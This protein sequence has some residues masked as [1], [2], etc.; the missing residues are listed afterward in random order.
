MA[1][2]AKEM[3]RKRKSCRTYDGEPLK[4][5]DRAA[6][7]KYIENVDNPFGVPVEFRLLDAD[8]YNL[9]SPVIAG[10]DVYMAAKAPKC[11]NFEIGL[12]YSFEKACLYAEHLGLGTVMLA[13][14]LNRRA[15]EKAMEVKDGEVMPVASPV[16]YPAAKRTIRENLMRKGLN[17]DDRRDP[18][19]IFFVDEYGHGLSKDYNGVFA[20]PLEMLRWAPSA[21]NRQPWRVVVSEGKVH[22]YEEQ[23]LKENSLGDVQ[24]MDVGIALCHFGLTMQEDG[25]EGRF[26]FEDPNLRKPE[27]V[28]Y[29]VSYER[30]E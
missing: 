5:M 19:K 30:T 1:F 6:L 26:V 18:E 9:M 11:A 28:H 4:V 12:G 24:K 25:H 15:F 17:A 21:G 13:A 14:S 27:N 3:I 23:S 20:E 7:E 16:G 29:I 10:A 2:S 8:K 22:F